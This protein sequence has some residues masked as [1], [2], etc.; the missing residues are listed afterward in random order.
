MKYARK[1]AKARERHQK[2]SKKSQQ[3]RTQRTFIEAR[4][5]LGAKE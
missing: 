1:N 3:R 2:A 5:E 4:R